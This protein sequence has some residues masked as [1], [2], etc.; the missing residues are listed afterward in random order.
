VSLYLLD[1]AEIYNADGELVLWGWCHCALFKRGAPSICH[2]CYSCLAFYT[3]PSI[4]ADF[5]PYLTGVST[6]VAR[7]VGITT[8]I[9]WNI[10]WML[11]KW[12][13]WRE[14]FSINVWNLYAHSD[15]SCHCQLSCCRSNRLVAVCTSLSILILIVE[16]DVPTSLYRCT[17]MIQITS[18]LEQTLPVCV[19]FL[20]CIYS[21]C[22]VSKLGLYHGVVKM[23][24]PLF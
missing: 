2:H 11:Q 17:V 18:F 12:S 22:V 13:Y 3:S 14:G 4:S 1:E 21:S 23:R 5:L 6:A 9:C 20:L 24:K 8:H 10:S 7:E 16:I 15:Y 19:M